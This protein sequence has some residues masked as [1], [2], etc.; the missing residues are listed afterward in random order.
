MR[1]GLGWIAGLWLAVL[2]GPVLAADLAL[3]LDARSSSERRSAVAFDLEAALTEAGFDVLAP[4]GGNMGAMRAAALGIEADITRGEVERLLILATGPMAGDGQDSWLLPAGTGSVSRLGIGAA[5]LSLNA[6]SAIAAGVDGPAVILLAP[7]ENLKVASGLTAGLAGLT[8]AEGVTYASGPFG[9]LIGVLR[10]GLLVPDTSFAEVARAAPRGIT[11]SGDL[12]EGTGLMGAGS[13]MVSEAALA[14]A[15]EDGFWQAVQ[16]VET[17]DAYDAYVRA[18]PA[19]RYLSKARERID[20]L[21]DAPERAARDGEA[22]LRLNREARREIQR[23]LSL[24]GFD[25]RGIDGVFGRGTRAAMTGWQRANGLTPSGYLD[26]DT[27]ARLRQQATERAREIEEEARQRQIEEDRR[28]RA[29][30]R[31]TGRNG[32]EAGLRAYLGRYPDG[33]FSEV[34]RARLDEFEQERRAETDRQEREAWDAARTADTPEAY[35]A[36]LRS[37]PESGFADAARDR[38][39][40]LQEAVSNAD[41]IEAARNEERQYT[42]AKVARVLIERRLE[43]LGAK[44]GPADGQFTEETRQAIRRF[45]RH[46]QLP[47]TGYI[48]RATMV[49]LMG[50]R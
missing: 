36:F 41:A 24:L 42:G 49:Q 29:Y 38:I 44:P 1:R 5:G 37:Y 31:N 18:Y 39:R 45:Q 20:W 32:D 7:T 8:E 22:A 33:A 2:T 9:G 4:D 26:A 35:D 15:R 3:V 43:Q 6:L 50:G 21:R 17:A 23:N 12:S 34:A 48:S 46:R 25:P 16:A 40:T 19:G 14:E 27:L 13:A 30:W 10:D 28:D 11:L 47:V